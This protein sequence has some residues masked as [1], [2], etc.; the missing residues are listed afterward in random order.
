MGIKNLVEEEMEAAIAA[1]YRAAGNVFRCM[2]DVLERRYGKEVAR[3]VATEVVRRKAEVAGEMAAARFGKGGLQQLAAAHRASFPTLQVLELTKTRYV[4]RDDRCPIVE[5]WRQSGLP[6][7][8]IKELGDSYCWGDLY[9]ARCFHPEINLEFQ[10]R[11][12]E[13]KPYCEWVFTLERND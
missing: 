1:G 2:M 9:F 4:I 3:E 5:G 10:A 12:A 7:E 8:R 13:G 6:E 11:L